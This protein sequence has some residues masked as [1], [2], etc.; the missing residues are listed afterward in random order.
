MNSKKPELDSGQYVNGVYTTKNGFTGSGLNCPK[1]TRLYDTS[2]VSPIFFM[3]ED[4][5]PGED[6]EMINEEIAPDILP[7][8]AISNYGKVLNIKSGKVMK[9]NFR[10]NGY[11]YYCLAAE[12]SKFGQKKYSTSRMVMGTFD[13]RENM[14]ELE[15]NHIN[16]DKSQNYY[17]KLMEDGTYES[18]LE[19][20]TPSENIVHSRETGLNNG[21]VLSYRDAHNIRE[22]RGQG[23]SYQKIQEGFYPQVSVAAIQL[24]CTNKSFYDPFYKPVDPKTMYDS[25]F[26]NMKITD[27]DA[28]RIR[29]LYNEG[30]RYEEIREKFY[31]EISKGTISDIVR[32]KTHNRT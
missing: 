32:G 29:A 26:N 6:Y 22:L 4:R 20:N 14:D 1:G 9:E 31:P 25:P 12:N 28:I 15:V 5:E 3:P 27:K 19:W 24:I 16:G 7:Y 21:P 13:P 23:Y 18:N 17:N 8:Y 30:Y 2:V 10:P 11:S